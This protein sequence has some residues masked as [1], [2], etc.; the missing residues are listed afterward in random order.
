[1]NLSIDKYV[2]LPAEKFCATSW[3]VSLVTLNISSALL[4]LR[5]TAWHRDFY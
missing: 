5:A 2:S 1:M 3:Y 4:N